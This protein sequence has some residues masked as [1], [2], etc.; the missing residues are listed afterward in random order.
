MKDVLGWEGREVEGGVPG[1]SLPSSQVV[2]L[3]AESSGQTRAWG[4]DLGVVF[5]CSVVGSFVFQD[6]PV[7]SIW[8]KEPGAGP[9]LPTCWL[10][11]AR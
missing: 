10:G 5:S 3:L 6:G 4:G 7:G 11:A 2:F 9:R 8:G 1:P